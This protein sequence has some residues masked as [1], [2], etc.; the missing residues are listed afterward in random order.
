MK[1]EFQKWKGSSDRSHTQ[2]PYVRFGRGNVLFMSTLFCDKLKSEQDRFSIYV[3]DEKRVIGFKS[4][5]D[6]THRIRVTPAQFGMTTF[7]NEHKPVY[8]KRIYLEYGRKWE[9]WI[10]SLDG[11]KIPDLN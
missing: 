4:E 2:C 6:G 9:M 10:G 1:Y 3:D 8:G 5:A 11:G 7:V